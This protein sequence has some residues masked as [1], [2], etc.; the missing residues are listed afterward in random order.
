M[1][2]RVEPTEEIKAYLKREL[3]KGFTLIGLISGGSML[4]II[5]GFTALLW[6]EYGVFLFTG[7]S[8]F[9]CVLL[10]LYFS[11]TKTKLFRESF[12]KG[13]PST[14]LIDVDEQTIETMG[15]EISYKCN[16]IQDIKKVLDFG[17]F[18]AIIFYGRNIDRRFI[19][20][21]DFIVQGTIE[22]FEQLFEGKI[23]RLKDN[24][25]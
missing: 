6:G 10:I 16:K 14:V 9:A 18:Y 15:G 1:E 12:E 22:E 23:V 20:Q 3:H 8:T 11:S 21:K 25:K 2:F 7:L 13:M 5:W 19:C 17:D 4:A 24:Q